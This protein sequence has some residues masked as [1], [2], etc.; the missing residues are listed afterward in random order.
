MLTDYIHVCFTIGFIK[1]LNQYFLRK[2]QLLLQCWNRITF[3][4]GRE[5]QLNF[6]V[7]EFE[8]NLTHTTV[9]HISEDF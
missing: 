1:Q 7:S 3:S 8:K 9:D 4:I 6:Q 5:K 2:F